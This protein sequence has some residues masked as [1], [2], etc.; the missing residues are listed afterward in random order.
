[1][2][3]NLVV[4]RNEKPHIVSNL[5]NNVFVYNHTDWF[6]HEK[7]TYSIMSAVQYFEQFVKYTKNHFRI[8]VDI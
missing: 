4:L 8:V 1:M 6:D 2:I 3:N 5:I 7:R